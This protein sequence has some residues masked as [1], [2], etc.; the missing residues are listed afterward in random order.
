M[1]NSLDFS[2]INFGEEKWHPQAYQYTKFSTIHVGI[3][4]LRTKYSS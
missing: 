2:E 3:Y 4:K 1:K